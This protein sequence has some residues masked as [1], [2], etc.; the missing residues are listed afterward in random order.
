MAVTTKKVLRITFNNALGS[1]VS[2]TLPEPQE[3]LT[4]VQIEAVMD[5]VI[6]KNIFL[7][8]GGELVSKRDIKIIDTST[9]D[10]YDPA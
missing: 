1:A 7:T 10:L 5:T 4:A 2:F 8:A 6:T 9:N 3:E